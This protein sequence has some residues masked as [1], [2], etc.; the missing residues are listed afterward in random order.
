MEDQTVFHYRLGT[1]DRPISWR[2]LMKSKLTIFVGVAGVLAICASLFAHHGASAYNRD[3]Q[4]SVKATITEFKWANPHV[5]VLFDAKDDKGNVAHWN[6][7]SI[8]PGMLQK[9]GW[10]RKTLNAGDQV[11]IVAYPS[12]TGSPV[13][14]LEK[15]V[16]ADGKEMT[17]RLLD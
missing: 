5:Y 10:T 2:I 13:C 3:K 8:N 4:M 16:L 1:V 7:E 6:C 17:S 9:Q 12:K 14:L 11:T 15:V